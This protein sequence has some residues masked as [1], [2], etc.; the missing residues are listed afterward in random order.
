MAF[1]LSRWKKSR[2]GEA[3]N[4]EERVPKKTPIVIT[5][6]KVKIELPPRIRSA[7]RTRRVVPEV[8]D[9]RLRVAFKAPLMIFGV[10][11][12]SPDS[13]RMRSKIMIVS[14]SE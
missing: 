3:I 8:I 1:V 12:W 10:G 5:R 13:S 7:K 9:V 11:K 4:H 2:R 6:A 14:F